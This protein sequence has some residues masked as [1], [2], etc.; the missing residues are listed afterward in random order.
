MTIMAMLNSSAMVRRRWFFFEMPT[1]RNRQRSNIP[2]DHH[3]AR[4]C[5]KRFATSQ[6]K[7]QRLKFRIALKPGIGGMAEHRLP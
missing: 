4:N 1:R 2:H 7:S 5:E 6:A 3:A